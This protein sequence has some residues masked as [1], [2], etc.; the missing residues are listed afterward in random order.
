LWNCGDPKPPALAMPQERGLR[1]PALIGQTHSNTKKSLSRVWASSVEKQRQ[2]FD[3]MTTTTTT[4]REA[5]CSAISM[6][7]W[8]NALPTTYSVPLSKPRVQRTYHGFMH[9]C[10]RV[11]D[12]H[13]KWRDLRDGRLGYRKPSFCSLMKCEG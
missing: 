1:F 12:N 2:L 4:A 3:F 11:I 9:A 6:N 5:S 8:L 10:V 7:R 13:R